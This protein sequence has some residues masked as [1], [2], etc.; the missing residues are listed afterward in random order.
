MLYTKY[1][2]RKLRDDLIK[3]LGFLK[4]VERGDQ[5]DF[6]RYFD[7]MKNNI[8]I[9]LYS[10]DDNINQIIYVLK[11]DWDASHEKLIGVQNYNPAKIHPEISSSQCLYFA[12]L[13]ADIGKFFNPKTPRINILSDA[14]K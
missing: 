7:T 2:L 6:Y 1:E 12:N 13:L 11:R 8:E 4:E 10:R 14:C 9:F 3:I 5:P